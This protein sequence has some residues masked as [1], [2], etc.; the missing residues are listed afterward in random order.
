MQDTE[1]IKQAACKRKKKK[2]QVHLSFQLQDSV[3]FFSCLNLASA[4]LP[5]VPMSHLLLAAVV[6][7]SNG[8]KE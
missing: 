4:S 1:E 7:L 8:M 5:F 6:L 2:N 3:I